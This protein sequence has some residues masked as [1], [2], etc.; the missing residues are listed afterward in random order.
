MKSRFFIVLAIL[1]GLGGC[2]F[3]LHQKT[4]G[5][6]LHKIIVLDPPRELHLSF[7]FADTA[8]SDL[9]KKSDLTKTSL[10][11]N[12]VEASIK[13][14]KDLQKILGQK[15]FYL[16]RGRQSFV[17][18]S[19]DDRYVIKFL[20]YHKYQ[21]PLTTRMFSCITKGQKQAF[22]EKKERALRAQESYDI[23]LNRLSL[24]TAVIFAH[25]TPTRHSYKQV[26]VY[27]GLDRAWTIDLDNVLF[28]V[29][30][31]AS[32]LEKEL[33]RS[34]LSKNEE[35]VHQLICSFLEGVFKRQKAGILNR[36]WR[37]ALRN[38]GVIG[39]QVIEVDIGSFYRDDA[40][41]SGDRFQEEMILFSLPLKEFLKKEGPEYLP[42]FEGKIKVLTKQAV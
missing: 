5:F 8:K 35:K 4:E 19:E 34:L 13:E 21:K 1:M 33:K 23:A 9:S 17:F 3:F 27:D 2:C 12:L 29:Q 42:A 15:F 7:S 28:I 38:S 22:L 24:E 16:G 6:Q 11:E 25:L 18:S 39:D 10:A 14:E 20:R 26:V 36:D 30:K 40:V 31:K 37:N 32:S 41:F